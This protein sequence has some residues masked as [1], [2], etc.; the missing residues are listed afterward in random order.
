M[1]PGI[2]ASLLRK[3]EARKC[4]IYSVGPGKCERSKE[5]EDTD[6]LGARG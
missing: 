4:E 6:V 5:G 3:S 1:G 2:L